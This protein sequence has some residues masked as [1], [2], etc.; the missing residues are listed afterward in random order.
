MA[1]AAFLETPE[2]RCLNWNRLGERGPL[3]SRH[4]EASHWDTEPHLGGGVQW[5]PGSLTN[6]P[7][8]PPGSERIGWNFEK[9]SRGRRRP[10]NSDRREDGSI[11][12]NGRCAIRRRDTDAGLDKH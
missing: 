4:D 9:K 3:F 8:E 10:R 6:H 1:V 7:G 5:N 2:W 11:E 12:A